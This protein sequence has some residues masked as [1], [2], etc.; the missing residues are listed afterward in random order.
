MSFLKQLAE[1]RNDL[2]KYLLQLNQGWDFFRVVGIMQGQGSQVD[3]GIVSSNLD[4]DPRWVAIPIKHHF[5]Y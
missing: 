3:Q 2:R 1:I 4:M 5:S